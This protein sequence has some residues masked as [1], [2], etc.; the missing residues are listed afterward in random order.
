[1][2]ATLSSIDSTAQARLRYL[3]EAVRKKRKA[4]RISATA[5]S[6]A[7][8]M[9][10]VT[11]HR[12]E[13]GEPSVTMGAYLNAMAVLGLELDLSDPHVARVQTD[14]TEPG[15][16]L[17]VRI[18]LSQYPQ[19]RRLAWQI[20]GTD[21]LTPREALDIYERNSRHLDIATMEPQERDLLEALKQVLPGGPRHV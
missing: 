19:L 13:K 10:R 12:I 5:A 14:H 1:M 9:S 4:L 21:E 3:G 16:F 20:H 11:W 15:Q 2:P 7:A 8:S 18:R 6:E 17:P